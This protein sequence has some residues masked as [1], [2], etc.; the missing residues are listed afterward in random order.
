MF[1]FIYV[2][3]VTYGL[4]LAW[5]SFY[6]YQCHGLHCKLCASFFICAC[7]WTWRVTPCYI[8]AHPAIC[9][10]WVLNWSASQLL[11]E[12]D[13]LIWWLTVRAA[14]AKCLATAEH[15]PIL[16]KQYNQITLWYYSSGVHS[17]MSFSFQGALAFNLFFTHICW[18][19]ELV[20]G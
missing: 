8:W 12:K 2:F 15:Q 10:G 16:L 20:T 7:L 4:R 3:Y 13:T 9:Q 6:R 18:Q 11:R 14:S 17:S 1:L 19:F 5:A